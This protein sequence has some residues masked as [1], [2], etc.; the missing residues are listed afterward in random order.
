MIP[1]GIY[2]TLTIDRREPQGFYLINEDEDEVLLPQSYI[3]DKMNIGDPVD[4]F[5]YCDSNDIEIATT[6]KPYFT[7][8]QFAYLR[9]TDVNHMGAFCDW[10]VNKELFIP[11]RNQKTALLA[12]QQVM[13]HMYID[14][15]T[16][17]LV[18]TT[19]LNKYLLHSAS[20]VFSLGEEVDLLV[21]SQTNLGY[22]AI[23][24]QQYSGLI[25]ENEVLEPLSIGEQCKGY[26]KPERSD[27]K[28]DLSLYPIGH[29]S[30][31]PNGQKILERLKK[32]DG[33]L[34]F[35]DKSN[36]ESIKSEF[37][38]SKKLFKK[39]LGGLYKQKLISIKEDGIHLSQT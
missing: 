32:N 23:I 16:Y 13:V 27:G 1:I 33:F 7:V 25:Y 22:K 38:I 18:G 10:G 39:S 17:R 11:F 36:P 21:Y 24:N 29:T 12:G 14:D 19:K 9:V 26:V 37:G 15:L 3:T 31:E 28:I 35:N 30:I 2:Q 20:K 4:V 34:P 5:V 6:E 8:D